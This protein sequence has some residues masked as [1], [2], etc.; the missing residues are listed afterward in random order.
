MPL[1]RG[2]GKSGTADH[3]YFASDEDAGRKFAAVCP[4]AG[5]A[6]ACAGRAGV[7][8]GIKPSGT[9]AQLF[10]YLA[11]EGFKA[12]NGHACAAF[13]AGFCVSDA[14]GSAWADCSESG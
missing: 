11:C 1:Q 2:K 13:Q 4:D 6:R 12:G 7:C 14:G 8:E 5:G 10:D 3:R 9:K